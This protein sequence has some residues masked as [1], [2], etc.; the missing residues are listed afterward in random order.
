MNRDQGTAFL[1]DF[2]KYCSEYFKKFELKD[3]VNLDEMLKYIRAYSKD[4][5]I[6]KE[7]SLF[8]EKKQKAFAMTMIVVIY[9]DRA[10]NEDRA[11]KK[12]QKTNSCRNDFI[13][14]AKDEL[15]NM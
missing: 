15:L 5:V 12:G 9:D 10:S 3:I 1:D 2:K 14:E 13:K 4:I 8:D 6:P 11:S 7:W